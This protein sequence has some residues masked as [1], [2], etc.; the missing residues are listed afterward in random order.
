MHSL[1]KWKKSGTKVYLLFCKLQPRPLICHVGKEGL[2][3]GSSGVSVLVSSPHPRASGWRRKQVDVYFHSNHTSLVIWLGDGHFPRP[4]CLN[5]LFSYLIKHGLS[6][7]P[8]WCTDNVSRVPVKK[9]WLVLLI[10]RQIK[11]W[12][13]PMRPIDHKTNSIRDQRLTRPTNKLQKRMKHKERCFFLN[14]SRGLSVLSTLWKVQE[15]RRNWHCQ[16]CGWSFVGPWS[17]EQFDNFSVGHETNLSEG[18]N[19]LPV[20]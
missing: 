7:A 20:Y 13:Q 4:S 9:L 3:R 6:F 10:S 16:C 17:R 15:G 2:G 14:P 19:E 12:Q 18:L 1:L 11:S 8:V 5:L